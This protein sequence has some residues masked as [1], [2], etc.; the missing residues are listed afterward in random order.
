MLRS[1]P[2]WM[3]ASWLWLALA[4]AGSDAR[5][6]RGE[7]TEP[8]PDPATDEIFGG[9]GNVTHGVDN[10]S[11]RTELRPDV[12]GVSAVEGQT[13]WAAARANSANAQQSERTPSYRAEPSE[14]RSSAIRLKT[15]R[16]GPVAPSQA[17]GA[18]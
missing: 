11:R 15:A 3:I 14:A 9:G 2:S 5:A 16:T 13:I 12:S 18:A 10:S 7:G 17:H 1:L 6:E 4:V 8:K